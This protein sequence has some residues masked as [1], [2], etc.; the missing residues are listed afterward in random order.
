MTRRAAYDV[1]RVLDAGIAAHEE[2]WFV[3]DGFG[4]LS[5]VIAAQPKIDQLTEM[6]DA[7]EDLYDRR[8]LRAGFDAPLW[9]SIP[10]P[11]V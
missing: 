2:L 7:A 9:D 10:F 6:V 3:L 11:P 8:A 1:V 5:D 4:S